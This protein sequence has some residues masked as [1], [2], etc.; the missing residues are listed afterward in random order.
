VNDLLSC[1]RE[2]SLTD[3]SKFSLMEWLMTTSDTGGEVQASFSGR[4]LHKS[5][6]GRDADLFWHVSSQPTDHLNDI[7]SGSNGDVT[8]MSFAQTEIA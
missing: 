8:Q 7:G 6:K 4:L 1:L 3:V 5:F 2:D